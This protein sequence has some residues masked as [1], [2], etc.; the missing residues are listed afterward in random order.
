MNVAIYAQH[1]L[2]NQN[3]KSIDDQVRACQKYIENNNLFLDETYIFADEVISDSAINRPGLQAL[4][5]AIKNK[6]IQAVVIDDLSRLSQSNHQMLAMIHKFNI[7]QVKIISVNAW[8]ESEKLIECK[9][10]YIAHTNIQTID[11]FDER[12]DSNW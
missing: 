2:E 6:E 11:L 9:P 10:Y 4:E 8:I 7:F 12:K 1:P 3:E 5:K